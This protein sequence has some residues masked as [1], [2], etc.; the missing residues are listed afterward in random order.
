MHPI[1]VALRR[2]T[3]K[4]RQLWE[5]TNV[6]V[7]SILATVKHLRD[8]LLIRFKKSFAISLNIAPKISRMISDVSMASVYG[9]CKQI[10]QKKL[11]SK[12]LTE[13]T[14]I[15]TMH[16]LNTAMTSA[17]II[18]TVQFFSNVLLKRETAASNVCLSVMLPQQSDSDIVS[19]SLGSMEPTSRRNT[20]VSFLPQLAQMPT[21]RYFPWHP[22]LLMPRMT[23]IGFGLSSYSTASLSNMPLNSSSLKR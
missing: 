10:A 5:N 18:L 19:R 11:H 4:S 16:C 7:F 13:R 17:V 14:K 9:I 8:S 15:H 20:E 12:Q 21:D 2:A 3:S 1:S 22:L 6:L 23:T